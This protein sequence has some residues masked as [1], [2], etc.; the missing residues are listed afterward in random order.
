MRGKLRYIFNAYRITPYHR[1]L[2]SRNGFQ[3]L[4]IQF[5]SRYFALF[6]IIYFKRHFN[7]LMYTHLFQCRYKDDRHIGKWRYPVL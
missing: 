7:S 5:R 4:L 1:R 3:H 6:V 2:I